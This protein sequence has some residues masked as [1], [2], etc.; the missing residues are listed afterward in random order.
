MAD[1]AVDVKEG[2]GSNP[3]PVWAILTALVWL[4]GLALLDLY[5]LTALWPHPTPSGATPPTSTSGAPNPAPVPPT[6]ATGSTGVTSTCPD[7]T[8]IAD[9]D[10]K[11]ECDCWNRV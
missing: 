10:R 3:V 7:C 9:E 5:F 4:V 1:T 6:G 11:A 8:K 2:P